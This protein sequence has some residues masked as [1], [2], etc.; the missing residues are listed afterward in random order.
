MHPVGHLPAE[1]DYHLRPMSQPSP[2]PAHPSVERRPLSARQV[3]SEF[4]ALLKGGARL[5]VAG[6]DR[7]EPEALLA[8]G[9]SPKHALRLFGTDF[10]V[11]NVRQN[12][13]LRFFVAWVAPPAP[14]R[15]PRRV[16][17][18][19]FYKDISLIWR[20]ASHLV[21]THD[22]LWIGKGD[23]QAVLK[24]GWVESQT[25]ES[26]T[27]LPLEMQDAMDSLVG[28]TKRIP[29]DTAIL[30]RVLRNAPQGRVAPYRDFTEPRRKAAAVRGGRINGGR[31]IARFTRRNDPESLVFVGGFEPDFSKRGLVELT[32]SHSKSYGGPLERYRFLSRNR[33]VQYLFFA[34][35][36]HVWIVPPQ[37]LTTELSSYGLRLIDVVIDDELCIPGYE[38]HFHEYPGEPE[39]LHS[40]IPEGF[41]GPPNP[42]DPDRADASPWLDRIPEERCRN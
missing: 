16:C 40:Q 17:A 35:P 3:G 32:R 42:G 25:V 36:R 5:E 10:Y 14:P 34:A 24:D 4:R 15:G 20:A 29:R 23:M 22:E 18:R 13:L 2:Q 39:S 31:S 9:Y 28:W 38:Y 1:F 30:S 11:T 8:D 27:D 26:T 37:A 33:Q 41:V 12:P 6:D 7:N 19:I 21:H